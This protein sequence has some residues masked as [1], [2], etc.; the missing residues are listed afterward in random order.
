[1]QDVDDLVV[2]VALSRCSDVIVLLVTVVVVF[3]V[4]VIVVIIF[5]A[6]GFASTCWLYWVRLKNI[7]TNLSK[8]KI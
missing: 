2:D 3:V 5:F 4:F 8:Q 7:I 1:M 6:R